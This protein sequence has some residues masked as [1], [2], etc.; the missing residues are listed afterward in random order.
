MAAKFNLSALC[1]ARVCVQ[2]TH[3][4]KI[5]L[6]FKYYKWDDPYASYK[7][8]QSAFFYC[9]L[10]SLLIWAL[11]GLLLLWLVLLLLLFLFAIVSIY[12]CFSC[13]DE[14]ELCWKFSITIFNFN[15]NCIHCMMVCVFWIGWWKL[16]PEE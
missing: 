2:S 8:M 9:A 6:E 14:A 15:L 5:M 10:C 12:I 7:F 11:R 4:T 3:T 13:S 16:W 1:N